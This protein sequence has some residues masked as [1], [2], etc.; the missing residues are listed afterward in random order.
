MKI[1]ATVKN[2]FE[3]NDVLVETDGNSKVIEIAPKTSGYGSSVNGAELLLLGLA[4]CFCND[5]YREAAKKGIV[6]AEVEVIVTGDFAA[7]GKAGSNLVY[8]AFV[9]SPADPKVID[10]L[11]QHTDKV[12]EIQNTVRNGVNISLIK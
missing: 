8:K 9:K 1:T 11:I 3:Q 6:I 5:L 2:K 7:E 4:T 10:E 12:A